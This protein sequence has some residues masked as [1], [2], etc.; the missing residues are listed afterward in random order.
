MFCRSICFVDILFPSCLSIA[1]ESLSVYIQG[2]LDSYKQLAADGKE[3]NDDQQV[4]AYSI[5]FLLY[6][7]RFYNFF[8]CD[9]T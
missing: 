2:K 1:N 8:Y 7:L 6:I 3:L 9:L 4:S 5:N